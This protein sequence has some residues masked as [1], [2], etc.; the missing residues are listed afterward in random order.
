MFCVEQLESCS[1][2]DLNKAVPPWRRKKLADKV[3]QHN[4]DADSSSSKKGPAKVTHLQTTASSK[5]IPSPPPE[6]ESLKNFVSRTIHLFT[7]F[8]PTACTRR[9]NTIWPRITCVAEIS[10]LVSIMMPFNSAVINQCC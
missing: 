5:Y 8:A 7:E 2:M 3:Q 1:A 10:G 6:F 9:T 4:E